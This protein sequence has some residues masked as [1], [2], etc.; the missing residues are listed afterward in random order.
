M[1][2]TIWH[3]PDCSQP[4]PVQKVGRLGDL[5]ESCPQCGRYIV[6]GR[7]ADGVA[8]AA[9]R[10]WGLPAIPPA[11]SQPFRIGWPT[12]RARRRLRSKRGSK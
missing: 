9:P 1:S 4:A 11:P 2:A 5:L 10:S 6:V 3:E 12:H 7:A 8:G